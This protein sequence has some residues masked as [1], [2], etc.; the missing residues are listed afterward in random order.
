MIDVL[1]SEASCIRFGIKRSGSIGGPQERT[2]YVNI[3]LYIVSVSQFINTIYYTL[4]FRWKKTANGI[5]S[6]SPDRGAGDAKD[7]YIVT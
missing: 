7:A 2:L 6:I 4:Y 3:L 5:R 1:L